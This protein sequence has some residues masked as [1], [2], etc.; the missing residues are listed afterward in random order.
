ME[1]SQKENG[2]LIL[3]LVI[4]VLVAFWNSSNYSNFI[5]NSISFS[6]Q[7]PVIVTEADEFNIQYV[8]RLIYHIQ[9]VDPTRKMYI[10]VNSNQKWNKD[11]NNIQNVFVKEISKINS[12]ELPRNTKF[13]LPVILLDILQIEE[14]AL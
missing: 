13:L 1:T 2:Y 10:Y 7:E 3:F 6:T 4:I 12:V 9:K 8:Y 11:L 5:Q 14:S